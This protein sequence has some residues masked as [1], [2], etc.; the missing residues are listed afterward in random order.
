LAIPPA[1]AVRVAFWAVVTAVTVAVNPALVAPAG[2]VTELGTVTAELLL[3]RLTASPPVPAAAER[4]TV[5]LSLPAP[6]NEFCAQ[7][8]PLSAPAVAWPVPLK[9]IVTLLGEALSLKTMLP[10]SVPLAVGLKLTVRVAVW[11]GFNV[12]GKLVPD[13]LKP[14][15]VMLPALT[16]SED[17]PDEVR[18]IDWLEVVFT[19][20]LPKLRVVALRFNAGT[21]ALRLMA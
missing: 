13:M 16:V 20:T 11:P 10:E 18:V 21:D 19:V 6:V 9:L 12:T 3:D 1:D 4:L 17:V 7:L 15:P 5:Q 2:T 8:S 14:V